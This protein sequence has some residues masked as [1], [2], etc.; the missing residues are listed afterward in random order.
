[1][2]LIQGDHLTKF[3]PQTKELVY[4]GP[5]NNTTGYKLWNPLT[6]KIVHNR[7]VKFFEQKV[8][9]LVLVLEQP[10]VN[11]N[12]FQWLGIGELSLSNITQLTVEPN[13]LQLIVSSPS[14]DAP[15][16]EEPTEPTQ[17]IPF[18]TAPT[19]PRRAARLAGREA[20]QSY[21]ST[22][23]PNDWAMLVVEALAAETQ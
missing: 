6:R 12:P 5:G 16:F 15:L 10:I 9:S 21:R 3:A 18:I 8:P 14:V 2:A 19:A 13:N 7:N 4:L 23:F 11:S 17:Q 22:T 20:I 1:M